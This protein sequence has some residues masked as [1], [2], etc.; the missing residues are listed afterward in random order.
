MYVLAAFERCSTIVMSDELG[1]GQGALG[2]GFVDHDS[3]MP[4]NGME[5][6]PERVDEVTAYVNILAQRA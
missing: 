4:V 6:I 2:T 1:T 3:K 5:E